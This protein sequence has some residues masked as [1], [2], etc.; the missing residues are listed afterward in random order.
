[1]LWGGGHIAHHV[2][3]R[4]ILPSD[5]ARSF[6]TICAHYHYRVIHHAITYIYIY[7]RDLS[8]SGKGN[9][10]L[11]KLL[12][13]LSYEKIQRYNNSPLYVMQDG[14]HNG[15][16]LKI[17][18][19]ISHPFSSGINIQGSIAYLPT[20]KFQKEEQMREKN[21]KRGTFLN[22]LYITIQRLLQK[23]EHM[24][25]S[26]SFLLRKEELFLQKRNSWQVWHGL[27]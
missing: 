3:R 20:F 5:L 25:K 10:R 24:I 22:F 9:S 14:R 12:G 2:W 8:P 13:R 15:F 7:V 27:L 11:T 21:L 17:S 19:V 6:S 26:F 23:Q 1:M 16:P 18:L 4:V